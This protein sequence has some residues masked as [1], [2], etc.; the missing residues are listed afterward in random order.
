MW[1]Y[2]QIITQGTAR[3]FYTPW[4]PRGADNGVF[5]VEEV[6]KS[7]TVTYT[8]LSKNREEEGSAPNSGTS[9]STVSGN[10][11]EAKVTGLLEL[12]RF[13]I[14]VSGTSGQS[15]IFRFLPPTWYDTAV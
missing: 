4:F 13:K 7:A 2:T 11:K 8:V 5:T 14:S 10:F 12:V 15:V 3:D 6:E 9:F 1:M